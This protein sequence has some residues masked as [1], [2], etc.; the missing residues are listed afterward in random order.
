LAE[1]YPSIALVDR[2]RAAEPTGLAGDVHPF[3]ARVSR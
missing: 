1:A 3:A 2:I